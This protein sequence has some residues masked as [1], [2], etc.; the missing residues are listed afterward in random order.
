MKE[1]LSMS[2]I[3][4]PINGTVDAVYL[5]IGQAIQ[6]GM[7]AVRVVNLSNL[8]VKAEVAEAFVSKVKKGND[9]V[10]VFP[11][12]GKEITGSISY[13]GNVIDPLNRTFLVEVKISNK[14]TDLHPNMVASLKIAD[15]KSMRAFTVP[16]NLIQTGD[17]GQY[18]Y[19]AE[20]D[21]GK[22]VA[23]KK[24]VKTGLNYNGVVEIISGLTEGDQIITTGYQDLVEGQQLSF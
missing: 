21:N 6:P 7:P 24:I 4:S 16:V 22:A 8:K 13:S 19:V 12:A 9:V 23:K 18:L 14:V 10:I 5:K 20:G 15:Y 2:K 17:E 3:K 11:D 1:Q